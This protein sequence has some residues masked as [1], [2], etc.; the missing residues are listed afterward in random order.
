MK[1]VTHLIEG[2]EGDHVLD[3]AE[4]EH[5]LEHSHEDA[6]ELDTTAPQLRRRKGS[7]GGKLSKV[8]EQVNT[9]TN[10]SNSKSELSHVQ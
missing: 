8:Q 1:D 5:R 10:S 7:R 2:K 9:I 6:E 3:G 4:V